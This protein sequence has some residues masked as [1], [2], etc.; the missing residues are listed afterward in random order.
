MGP[1]QARNKQAQKTVFVLN[2][3]YVSRRMFEMISNPAYICQ[4]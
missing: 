4:M 1:L 2:F 3:M